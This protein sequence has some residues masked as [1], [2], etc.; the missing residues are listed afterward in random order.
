[1]KEDTGHSLFQNLADLR[2]LPWWGSL[3]SRQTVEMDDGLDTERADPG[4]SEDGAAG[5]QE[6]CEK[7]IPVVARP[8][9][10]SVFFLCQLHSQI[11]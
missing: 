11:Q 3:V 5:G 6:T 4:K 7:E 10:Q 2:L 1:M 9:S 8:L